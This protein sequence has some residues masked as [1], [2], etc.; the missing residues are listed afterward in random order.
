MLTTGLSLHAQEYFQNDI[1]PH[2]IEDKWL[3]KAIR[4]LI[5]EESKIDQDFQNGRGYILIK[6]TTVETDSTWYHYELTAQYAAIDVANDML[7]P[8][9]YGYVDKRM[10]MFFLDDSAHFKYKT[11]VKSAFLKKLE[12]YLAPKVPVKKM[13]NGKMVKDKN[14]RPKNKFKMSPEKV[15]LQYRQNQLPLILSDYD[16]SN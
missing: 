13:V 7:F 6:K 8:E 5:T 4:K 11:G 3:L 12:R 1:R 15:S 10:V 14:Y 9:Y 2:T 16:N